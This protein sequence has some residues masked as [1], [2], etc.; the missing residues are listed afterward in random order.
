MLKIIAPLESF[1]TIKG[2]TPDDVG[3]GIIAWT[4]GPMSVYTM[5]MDSEEEV[6]AVLFRKMK[7][8][9]EL[10]VESRFEVKME[11]DI[12]PIESFINMVLP[13]S[14]WALRDK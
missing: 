6:Y 14:P 4:S 2:F 9:G 7:A 13:E 1:L 12:P 3:D 10:L 5:R 11:S 8:D